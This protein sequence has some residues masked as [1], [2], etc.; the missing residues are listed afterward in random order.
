[1]VCRMYLVVDLSS[2]HDR[3]DHRVLHHDERT[4]QE[5][6]D[7]LLRLPAWVDRSAGRRPPGP[8]GHNPPADFELM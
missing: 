5:P 7:V 1:M 8:N 2:H 4:W 6:S 3:D